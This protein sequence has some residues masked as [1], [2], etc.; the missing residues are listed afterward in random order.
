MLS[1]TALMAQGT[2]PAA[3]QSQR[4]ALIADFQREMLFSV[5][6]VKP[7][8]PN[9][10][11]YQ[12]LTSRQKFD[13]YLVKA[14]SPWNLLDAG[15][16][17]STW[18]LGDHPPFGK[19]GGALAKGFGAALAQ[20]ET[21]LFLGRFLFP[22]LLRQDPRYFP[23]AEGSSKFHR[24][25]YAASRVFMTRS[26][27]GGQTFNGGYILGNLASAGISNLYITN[28]DAGSIFSDFAIGMVTDAG[29]NVAR[30]FWPAFRK[31]VPGK[32]T[33]D[34]CDFAIGANNPKNQTDQPKKASKNQ[35]LFGC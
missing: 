8:L 28:R 11:S 21:S 1:I 9:A 20:Q 7:Q 25:M 6:A 24:A 27:T 18:Q 34:L 13:L 14:T 16:T 32:Y 26:D 4:V 3:P 31:R 12:P 15:I 5:S 17:T 23:A 2:Y 30:E 19:G 22:A 35:C 29:Y 10:P 33:K